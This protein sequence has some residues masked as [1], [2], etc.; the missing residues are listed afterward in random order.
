M[1]CIQCLDEA[2]IEDSVCT[3]KFCL[4]LRHYV[5]HFPA[6]L[7]NYNG[8]TAYIL[9]MSCVYTDYSFSSFILHAGTA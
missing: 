3:C 4:R 1:Y 5:V 9:H 8:I 6:I 2:G 7:S